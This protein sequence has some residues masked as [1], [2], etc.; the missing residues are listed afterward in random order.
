MNEGVL[1]KY[2]IDGNSPACFEFKKPSDEEDAAACFHC[3]C[4]KCGRL[5]HLRC[6][7][8]AIIETHLAASHHFTLNPSRT[9]L[10][11]LCEDCRNAEKVS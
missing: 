7:E 8:L 3:K 9:V 5:I 2:I 1:Q 4:E 10:Y 6:D 11:G